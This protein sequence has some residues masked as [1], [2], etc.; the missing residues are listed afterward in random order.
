MAAFNEGLGG[1]GAPLCI[2]SEDFWEDEE[3]KKGVLAS[4]HLLGSLME[5]M[6]TTHLQAPPSGTPGGDGPVWPPGGS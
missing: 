6:G 5:Q 2:T 4:R 3:V 1:G